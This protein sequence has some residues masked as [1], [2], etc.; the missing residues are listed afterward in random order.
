MLLAENQTE[1]MDHSETRFPSLAKGS[2]GYVG[3]ALAAFRDASVECF[4]DLHL[5]YYPK[6]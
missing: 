5:K 1:P 3:L 4:E 2:R 6:S